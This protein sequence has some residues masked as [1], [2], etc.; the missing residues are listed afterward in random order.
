MDTEIKEEIMLINSKL[1]VIASHLAILEK[2]NAG[3]FEKMRPSFLR[4]KDVLGDLANI[5]SIIRLKQS[6]F[7]M[8]ED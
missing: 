8:N 3:F 6:N 5:Q 7:K 4:K 1:E 2:K